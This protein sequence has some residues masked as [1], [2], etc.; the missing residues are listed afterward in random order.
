MNA[1]IYTKQGEQTYTQKAIE[2]LAGQRYSVVQPAD[3]NRIGVQ[4]VEENGICE[5]QY[6]GGQARAQKAEAEAKS[7]VA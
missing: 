5:W 3:G 7:W 6:F 4:M 2:S 1:I